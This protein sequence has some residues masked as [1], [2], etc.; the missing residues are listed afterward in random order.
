VSA[1][2]I[3][4]EQSLLL[5]GTLRATKANQMG[6]LGFGGDRGD[7]VRIMPEAS[8]A[9]LVNRKLAVGGEY[10]KQPH[11][12]GV[13]ANAR[14]YYDAF[15]AYFPTKN[16]SVTAAYANL[17]QITIFNTKNQSGWYLSLQSGF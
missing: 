1:T 12:L 4:F 17:G 3:L 10:R 13:D 14:G 9:Y 7:D 15:V 16:L 8:V 2:K 6:I 5:N 11:D